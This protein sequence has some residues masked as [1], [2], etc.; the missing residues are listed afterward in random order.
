M[1]KLTHLIA[2]LW[3]LL[4]AR[5]EASRVAWTNFDTLPQT[6]P[7]HMHAAVMSE[8]QKLERLLRRKI[9][10]LCSNGTNFPPSLSLADLQFCGNERSG[11]FGARSE[12]GGHSSGD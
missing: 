3:T 11:D 9:P 2:K 4:K 1:E 10:D 8:L 6:L 5:A 12:A 7:R